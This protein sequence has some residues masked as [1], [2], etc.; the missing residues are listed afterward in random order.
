MSHS[1]SP[2]ESADSPAWLHHKER[3]NV[4]WLSVMSTLS[5]RLG[6]RLSRVV[7][8]GIALYFVLFGGKARRASKD[9]LARCLGRP[10]SWLDRYRHV[11]AFASTIH[12][13][14]YLLRDRFDTFRISLDGA[15]T[16]HRHHDAGQGLLLFGAH[17]GSFEVLRAMARH[18]PDLSVSMAMY[19]ENAQRINRALSAIN[20]NAMQDIIPLGSLGAMLAVHRRLQEGALVGILAD[21]AVGPDQYVT[22]PFLG[23][24]A[25]FP[26][27]PFRMAL[28]LGHPVYFMA[29]LYLGGNRYRV[30][31][32]MLTDGADLAGLERDAAIE[33]LLGKYVAALERQCRAQPFNWFNFYD[34]WEE[35]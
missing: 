3:G 26:T 31:F 32:E 27:G 6:R 11:L 25:R 10:A 18:R 29:G 5:L 28:M 9:Y 30:H 24:P 16:L 20:P 22:L 13:R 21:R 14:I 4:F 17:L 33:T 8:A 2:P 15:D 23:A 19:P 34:F 35:A 7:L 12:D 1:N